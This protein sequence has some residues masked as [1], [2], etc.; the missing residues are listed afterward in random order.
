MYGKFFYFAV[1]A[2][3]GV[4]SSLSLFLPYFFISVI[5]CFLLYRYKG[6]KKSMLGLMIFAYLGFLFIGYISKIENKTAISPSTTLFYLEFKD[7]RK[8]D[9]DVLQVIAADKRY[10]EKVMLRYKIKS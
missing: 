9:G 6:Y 5:Y 10:K 1:A 4:L 8:I 2:L 3:L 7:L